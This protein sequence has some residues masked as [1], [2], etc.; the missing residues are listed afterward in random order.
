MATTSET[1]PEARSLMLATSPEGWKVE[2]I[3]PE[4]VGSQGCPIALFNIPGPR[5]RGSTAK[6]VVVVESLAS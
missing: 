2:G 1:Q 4:G 3:G 6:V 5:T